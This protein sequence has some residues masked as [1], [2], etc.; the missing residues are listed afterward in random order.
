MHAA[1]KSLPYGTPVVYSPVADLDDGGGGDAAAAAAAAGSPGNN[2]FSRD[3]ATHPSPGTDCQESV[4][5]Q[6][7]NLVA[8]PDAS[9][10]LSDWT[11][12]PGQTA[13][14]SDHRQRVDA[15]A[16]IPLPGGGVRLA[17]VNYNGQ[18][19]HSRGQHDADC[20]RRPPVGGGVPAAA[21]AA[22]A[23]EEE[24]GTAA[25]LRLTGDL[26]HKRACHR[27]RPQTLFWPGSG[28]KVLTS[29]HLGAT[30]T[31][32]EVEDECRKRL[33][34]AMTQV[35]ADLGLKIL[36]TFHVVTECQLMH[37]DYNTLD[38]VGLLDA[39]NARH[40]LW[41]PGPPLQQ[42]GGGGWSD[43]CR[44]A[45]RVVVERRGCVRRHLETVYPNDVILGPPPVLR[46][47]FTQ[48]QL[49]DFLLAE[50]DL[51]KGGRVGGFLLV[52][53]GRL[54]A[55][56]DNQGYCIQRVATSMDEVGRFTRWQARHL[57][58]GE[59]ELERE[60]MAEQML[61][62][63]CSNELTVARR[64]F[65]DS[66]ELIGVSYF[67]WLVQVKGY[68]GYT[69]A[70]YL[71]F[72]QALYLTDFFI[73]MAQRRHDIQKADD[74]AGVGGVEEMTLKQISNSAYGHS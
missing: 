52:R 3:P 36:V 39:P 37:K 31:K 7:M 57:A 23:E 43:R 40:T 67:K 30:A 25:R 12:G 44:R 46:K 60:K 16:S 50:P 13:L 8:F 56:D 22:A 47:P 42:E 20:P 69:I 17:F 62:R 74:G 14:G 73:D 15:C 45:P 24:G 10:I 5:V 18:F 61:L 11:A 41:T 71:F 59:D 4:F 26:A 33:A 49:V 53:G 54:H 35:A 9:R 72:P 70:H 2:V 27:H 1:T 6:W 34:A 51:A 19:W 38:I 58:S 65:P 21:A 63:Y 28:G 68:A 48:Q 66:G 55:P 32:D 29:D 64:S